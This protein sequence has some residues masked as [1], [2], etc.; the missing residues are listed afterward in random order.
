MGLRARTIDVMGRSGLTVVLVC[1]HAAMLLG[2][3]L[4][5]HPT[6]PD[7]AIYKGLAI[8]MEHGGFSIWD[9]IY[10]PAPVEV[11][12]THGYPFLMLLLRRIS[13][14]TA[15]LYLVQALMHLA[16]ILIVL[17]YLGGGAQSVVRR[18]LFLLLLLPQLQLMHYVGQVFP[19]I[20]M[21]FLLTAWAVS[22]VSGRNGMGHQLLRI[23]LAA[24]SFWVRPIA[25]LLPLF[26]VVGDVL[27]MR[28]S[29]RW[30]VLRRNVVLLV[31]FGLLGPLPFAMWNLRTHGYFTPLT[32]TGS[33]VI[34]NMGIWQL[35]LPGYGT[36]HYFQYSTFGREF[37]STV[38]DSTAARNYARYQEQWQRILAKT[39]TF[40]SAKDRERVP[41]MARHHQLW[42]TRSARYTV[43]LDH[44]I[45]EENRAMIKEEPGYYLA[46][47]LYAAVRLWVTN[48]NMPIERVLYRPSPGEF[49]VIGRPQGS[50]G[51]AKALLPF[52]IT[53]ITFGLGIPYLIVAVW[54]NRQ[55]WYER[56]Y[57]LYFIAYVW[58]VHIPMAI[59]SRYTVPVH[60][61]AIA[62]I[63]LA[64]TD[65]RQE[66][67]PVA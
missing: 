7:E 26:I 10:E 25:I 20:V 11:H 29:D 46:S 16:S 61:L 8:S 47:R 64:L 57:M 63:T 24:S 34:S 58:W 53:F 45:A 28:G 54:R 38:D 17:R 52:I 2:V 66:R 5:P 62:C 3:V 67:T 37:V 32:L 21:S 22:Y 4:M 6:S 55:R 65:R 30:I 27:I 48:I 42:P 51:W 35:K 9:G 19:E 23:V 33:A 40:M 56:R 59:Q 60:V 44:A 18:N 13:T 12:R 14:G 50:G 31:G 36:M 43:A 41:F 49:P 1:I 15:L 39:D